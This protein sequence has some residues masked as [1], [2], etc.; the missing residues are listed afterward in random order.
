VSRTAGCE[1]DEAKIRIAVRA[2][3]AAPRPAVALVSQLVLAE[4][5][6]QLAARLFAASALFGAHPAM[7]Q[8]SMIGARVSIGPASLRTC[9]QHD[10]LYCLYCPAPMGAIRGLLAHLEHI[11]AWLMSSYTGELVAQPTT[12]YEH[13]AAMLTGPRPPRHCSSPRPVG[14]PSNRQRARYCRTRGYLG[15]YD[16]RAATRA[17]PGRQGVHV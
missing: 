5:G 3:P 13:F 6:Q 11:G 17:G 15:R 1:R 12:R 14:A 16:F 7:L 8:F 2:E 4:R 9:L 10:L